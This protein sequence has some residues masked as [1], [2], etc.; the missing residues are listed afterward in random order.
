MCIVTPESF[1]KRS[2]STQA[3]MARRISA[4]Q[5]APAPELYDNERGPASAV[6]V[7]E[8]PWTSAGYK[9]WLVAFVVKKKWKGSSSRTVI[10]RKGT[11]I[12]QRYILAAKSGE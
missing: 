11:A 10:G 8:E 3:S 12:G 6:A 9:S 4:K 5:W 2:D 7:R 1:S